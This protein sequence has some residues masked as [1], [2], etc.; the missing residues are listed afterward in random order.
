MGIPY[1][2]VIVIAVF[3]IVFFR[4][5]RMERSSGILWAVLSITVSLLAYR[6][7][8]LGF[9]GV[10]LSQV[11]LFVSITIYRMRK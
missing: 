3:A 6:F 8:P 4:A 1:M 10:L 11:I 2:A 5:G 7:T 9:V